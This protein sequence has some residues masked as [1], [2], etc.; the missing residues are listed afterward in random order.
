MKERKEGGDGER[1]EG[2]LVLVLVVVVREA[3][4]A[5]AKQASER[6]IRPMFIS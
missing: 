3:S 6:C 5:T 4:K 2:V 1:G